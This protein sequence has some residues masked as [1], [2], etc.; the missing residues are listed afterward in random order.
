M[1]ER[2]L[3]FMG[4]QRP[5]TVDSVMHYRRSKSTIAMFAAPLAAALFIGLGALRAPR[6][7]PEDALVLRADLASRTLTVTRGGDIVKEYAVAV[8]QPRYPTPRGS[9]TIR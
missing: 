2:A 6:V 5:S 3:L 4:E 8:G 1:V 7:Q 9:Y